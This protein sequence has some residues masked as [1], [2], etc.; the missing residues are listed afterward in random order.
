VDR[1]NVEAGGKEWFKEPNGTGPFKLKA[2]QDDQLL[3]LERNEDFYR[4]PPKVKYVVFRLFA[5]IPVRM[6][7]TGEVDVAP[8]GPGELGRIMDPKNPLSKELYLFPQLSTFYIGFNARKPPF[9]EAAVR[10]AFV[11]ALDIQKLVD[12][13]L[14]GTV[15]KAEGFLPPGIPGYDPEF[16]GLP[17]DP[18]KAREAI[19]QSSYGEVAKL[20]TVIYTTPGTGEIGPILS[21][22]IDMW[23]TNLGVE[24]RV[25]Q[26]DPET[27]FYRL[28]E[29]LDNLFDYGWVA[30]FPDPENFL[31]VL[32]HSGVVNN[33]GGYSNPEVDRLLEEA[34]VELDVEK[35]MGLYRR[36]EELLIE[37]AAAIP[38]WHDREY[39]LIKPYV[40]G[41]AINPQGLMTLSR[42]SLEP[43]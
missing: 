36:V 32:F 15:T 19:A 38:L 7:E 11:M 41:F 12:V 31:D 43:H 3:V 20:P 16:K 4:E 2:W 13:V 8:V 18:E 27:Y 30:D 5:G 42:V 6:Y 9:D 40:K 21:A 25:R 14:R 22:I 28:S 24:V 33:P 39:W 34:R 37:D 1:E 26:I 35:R 17:F 23:R 29:E 10:R